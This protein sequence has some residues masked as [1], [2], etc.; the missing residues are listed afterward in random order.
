MSISFLLFGSDDEKGCGF[1]GVR[2]T[3][4]E[5]TFRCC[6]GEGKGKTE[7]REKETDGLGGEEKMRTRYAKVPC[8]ESCSVMFHS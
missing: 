5:E 7:E 4:R 2:K 3:E 1:S 8:K 6:F